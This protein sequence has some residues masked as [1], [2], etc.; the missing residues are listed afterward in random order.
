LDNTL[1][2]LFL[3]FLVITALIFTIRKGSALSFSEIRDILLDFL[4]VPVAIGTVVIF[5]LLI[6]R[7]DP[8]RLIL[9]LTGQLSGHFNVSFLEA[10]PP[11]LQDSL[12]VLSVSRQDTDGDDFSEWVVFY[13]FDV[14][15]SRNPVQGVV[16][17]NDRGNP[18]VIFPYQ[19]RVPDRDYLSEG[20][21]SLDLTQIPVDGE[22][23]E[24]ILVYGSK[25]LSI[26]R[27]QQN[28]EAWEPPRDDPPRYKA[29]GFFRGTEGVSLDQDRVTVRNRDEF[30][31]SQL[32]RRTIYE[33][34]PA[35]ESYFDSTFVTLAP[36]V[37]ETVDFLASPPQDVF[38]TAY[39]E[40]VVL[41]FYAST[42]GGVD[43]SLCRHAGAGW[44]S[45]E[46]LAPD[47]DPTK[48]SALREFQNGNAAYFGLTSLSSSQN[49]VVRTLRYY[50][51][52]E[53]STGQSIY[54][55]VEPQGNCVEIQLG[56]PIVGQPDTL[57]FRMR[58][59]NGKWKIERQIQ[60][61]DCRSELQVLSDTFAPPAD[62]LEPTPLP[63][64][65]PV[66]T[67]A[68]AGSPTQ[69]PPSE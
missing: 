32:A 24:E 6:T 28:S 61:G 29:I 21:V 10:I 11:D 38:D 31:R 1:R 47:D 7:T 56:H 17:D 43:D 51:Q 67:E 52:V 44:D 23:S 40:K 26:F 22:G 35:T 53:R 8:M 39:P 57:S 62:S 33:Y 5:A 37:M 4:L 41:A 65:G 50:P 48:D 9:E 58:F 16:Y 45:K 13:Q 68:P 34:Q 54:T 59:V 69:I 63:P 12:K 64:L 66:P 20:D 30:E 42:C 55:G 3:V 46:F 25:E 14:D 36:P 18:P 15:S 19:L 60:S 2:V 27:F 49:I